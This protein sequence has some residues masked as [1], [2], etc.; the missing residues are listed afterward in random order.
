M[1]ENIFYVKEALG[2]NYKPIK[3]IKFRTMHLGTDSQTLKIIE[4]KGLNERGK[5]NNDPRIIP[6]GKFLRKYH[7]DEIP[8]FLS[9][10]GDLS[11]VGVR[12]CEKEY[13]NS[14]PKKHVDLVLKFKPGIFSIK[15]Y[16]LNLRDK[17][18]LM[19]A[20]KEYINQKLKNPLQTDL[21]YLQ[22]IFYNKTFK[23]LWSS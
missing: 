18:D 9:L 1:L 10:G 13:W 11:L 2:K 19:D 5:I 22:G 12:P 17:K 4:E 7:F 16:Y 23:S 15:E 20:E 3:V 21:K 14:F 6:F 8:N